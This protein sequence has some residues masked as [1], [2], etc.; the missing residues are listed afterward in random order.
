[1]AR[2]MRIHYPGAVY[3][4]ILRGNARQEIFFDELDRSRFFLLM[5]EGVERFGH[6]VM[7]FCLMTNH[8]H[9]AIQVG[10]VPLSRIVQNLAFRY[11][12]WVNWRKKRVGHLFQGRYKAILVD[13]DSYLSELVA[14]IHLNPV[15]A[16]MVSAPEDYPWCSHRAY[17][18]RDFIPWLTPDPVLSLFASDHILARRQFA[19]FVKDRH[20]EGHRQ[21]FHGQGGADSRVLGEDRFVETVLEQ[22]ESRPATGS[23]VDDVLEI[24]GM[25]CGVTAAELAAKSQE[26]RLSEARNLAAWAVREFTSVSL[27]ELAPLL[28]REA[29]T[30]SSGIRRLQQKA[31]GEEKVAGLMGEVKLAVLQA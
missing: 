26:R 5:Q 3:H 28:G 31:V 27:A 29:S 20:N 19:A 10:E 22:A 4:V 7:A 21:E 16:L 13:V 18:G 14:Y 6:R 17:L 25:V 2:K 12:R 11:S 23:G 9:L 8:V 15:R 1:M 30:L 24:V